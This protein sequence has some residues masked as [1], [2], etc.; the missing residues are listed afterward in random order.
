MSIA[1][2]WGAGRLW[3]ALALLLLALGCAT[4]RVIPAE[5][6]MPS[7]AT[8]VMPPREFVEDVLGKP[9]RGQFWM[10]GCTYTGTWDSLST[11]IGQVASDHGYTQVDYHSAKLDETL[12]KLKMHLDDY[13]VLYKSPGGTTTVG[14]I[15]IKVFRDK[16]ARIEGTA[17]YVLM[18]GLD[19]NH[20][21]EHEE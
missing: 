11:F 12:H 16:G 21:S 15:N 14:A 17:Q 19:L 18:G 5:E 13:M 4:E 7:G 2:R 20:Y 1:A 10:R 3:L 9:S 8:E 6:L